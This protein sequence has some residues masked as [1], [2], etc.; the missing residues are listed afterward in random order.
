MNI[1]DGPFKPAS[2]IIY[3]GDMK[4]S[5]KQSQIYSLTGEKPFDIIIR[6]P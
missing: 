4:K 6:K 2:T 5:E 3:P 1:Y